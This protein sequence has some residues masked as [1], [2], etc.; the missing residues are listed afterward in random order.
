MDNDDGLGIPDFLLVANRKPLTPDQ[1]ARVER[2]FAKQT[3]AKAERKRLEDVWRE[4]RKAQ[5]YK[6]INRLK[7]VK[8]IQEAARGEANGRAPS[9]LT[10]K[11]G[12]FVVDVS[13]SS[14]NSEGETPCPS[15][16]PKKGAEQPKRTPRAPK[17]SSKRKTA[18][19]ARRRS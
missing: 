9:G 6:R 7:E 12:R 1:R 3:E 15:P 19:R 14:N 18:T 5:S 17:R 2:A 10:Y 4:E 8:A 13:T 11:S 16:T